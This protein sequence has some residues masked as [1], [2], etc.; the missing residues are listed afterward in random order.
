MPSM[1]ASASRTETL[2]DFPQAKRFQ[3]PFL[4]RNGQGGGI[5]SIKSV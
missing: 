5:I 2:G 1:K 4:D 3:K